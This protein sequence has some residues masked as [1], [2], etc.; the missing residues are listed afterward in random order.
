M[1]FYSMTNG[2]QTGRFR[3]F[4]DND[5][6]WFTMN[7]DWEEEESQWEKDAS[8]RSGGFRF[9]R[10]EFE[11]M[12]DNAGQNNFTDWETTWRLPMGLLT[13][14]A[15][16]LRGTIR[17]VGRLALQATNTDSSSRILSAGVPITF[18][19]RF[20]AIPSSITFSANEVS[21]N[22]GG[23][24]VSSDPTRDG[25]VAYTYQYIQ[26]LTTFWWHGTY[27]AIACVIN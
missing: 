4:A 1:L 18:R 11:I 2:A 7:A 5:D 13:N 23:D 8:G 10:S 26:S 16:E 21:P 25:F 6:I 17:E 27:T 15:F 14:S 12:T 20:P 19:N 9:G 24:P 22:W 3:I